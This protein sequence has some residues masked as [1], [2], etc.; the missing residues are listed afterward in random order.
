MNLSYYEIKLIWLSLA[1]SSFLVDR[2]LKELGYENKYAEL[3]GKINNFLTEYE[4]YRD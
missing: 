1:Q 3:L 4:S 2:S